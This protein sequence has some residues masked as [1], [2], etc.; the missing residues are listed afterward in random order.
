L[1][2]IFEGEIHN[3]IQIRIGDSNEKENK[4]RKEKEEKK[5]TY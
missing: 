3:N 4:I 1:C 2:L 5:K